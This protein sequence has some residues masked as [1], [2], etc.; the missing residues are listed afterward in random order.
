MPEYL[1]PKSASS[2]TTN[3]METLPQNVAMVYAP[4]TS[5]TNF[6]IVF[7]ISAE[8]SLITLNT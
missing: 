4:S 7:P 8:S 3:P 1:F 6:Q 5:V 2:E